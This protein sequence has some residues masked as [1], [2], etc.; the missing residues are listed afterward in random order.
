MCKKLRCQNKAGKIKRGAGWGDARV[1]VGK[2][3]NV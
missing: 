1:I 2:K 3:V